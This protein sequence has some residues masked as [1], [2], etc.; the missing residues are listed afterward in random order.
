MNLTVVKFENKDC[1]LFC[2][3]G[4]TLIS[5]GRKG[6]SLKLLELSILL[7]WHHCGQ[8]LCLHDYF[9]GT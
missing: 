4:H 3:G 7:S 2:G 1:Q 9:G 5:S 6:L 8:I